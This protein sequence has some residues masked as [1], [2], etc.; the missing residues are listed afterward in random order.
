MLAEYQERFLEFSIKNEVLLFGEFELKSGRMSPYFFNAGR[1]N[2][3]GMLRELGA[4]YAQ[5]LLASKLPFDLLFGPAY[6]GIPLVT[7]TVIA[8]AERHGRDVPY[9]FNRKEAK[10]HGEGGQLVGAE[11]TGRVVVVDDVITAGTA[12]REVMDIISLYDASLTGALVAID[13]QEKGASALSAIQ[14]LER[15]YGVS[16]VSV[17][18]LD[19]IISYIEGK[20]GLQR[21]LDRIKRY[22]DEF[23]VAA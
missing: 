8:L 2:R 22:R 20:A 21:E 3:G 7:A 11:L 9:V 15:D 6:K 5:A 17:V 4:F 12:I 14:E 19:D 13:R 23:G 1:F 16:V 18:K 10:A